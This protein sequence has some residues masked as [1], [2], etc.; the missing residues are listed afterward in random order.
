MAACVLDALFITSPSTPP[1]F[2]RQDSDASTEP[3]PFTTIFSL[4]TRNYFPSV[5]DSIVRQIPDAVGEGKEVLKS[6]LERARREVECICSLFD[7]NSPS[8]P[9][10]GHVAQLLK[11]EKIPAMRTEFVAMTLSGFEQ[12]WRDACGQC[13]EAR[14]HEVLD[15]KLLALRA[16]GNVVSGSCLLQAQQLRDYCKFF[17]K[18]PP[19]VSDMTHIEKLSEIISL[20][21]GAIGRTC[22]IEPLILRGAQETDHSAACSSQRTQI[23]ATF[24]KFMEAPLVSADL[25]LV[26]KLAELVVEFV[27]SNYD[28]TVN[29][30]CP[31]ECEKARESIQS[32]AKALAFEVSGWP[33]LQ[34]KFQQIEIASAGQVGGR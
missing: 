2:E 32:Q 17:S 7:I 22:S 26:T 16:E 4:H 34:K 28:P 18:F 19:Q 27:R 33:D 3:L 30:N 23:G 31:S 15:Q 13:T 21:A 24:E 9:V 6:K 8:E 25:N 14:L 1:A 29:A 11:Y 10:M 12:S 5:L 20:F